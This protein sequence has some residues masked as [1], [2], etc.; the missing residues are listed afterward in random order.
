MR[1]TESNVKKF[2]LTVITLTDRLRRKLI[3]LLMLI[4]KLLHHKINDVAKRDIAAIEFVV[5]NNQFKNKTR[6]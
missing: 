3:N 4:Y 5:S 1:K 6:D 2:Y